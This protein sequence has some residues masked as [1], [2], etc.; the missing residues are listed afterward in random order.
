MVSPSRKLFLESMAHMSKERLRGTSNSR[1]GTTNK[2]Q[3]QRFLN[4]PPV[5]ENLGAV[6]N[7]SAAPIAS[8]PEE[9]I[10]GSWHELE[11]LM[12]KNHNSDDEARPSDSPR[13]S[14]HL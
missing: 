12:P 3:A 14:F 7:M 10:S 13:P 5:I 6:I 8:I 2:R 9:E 11:A 1:R 4:V